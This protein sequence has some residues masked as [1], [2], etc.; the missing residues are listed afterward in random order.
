MAMTQN[1]QKLIS[2]ENLV[3]GKI[4]CDTII[5]NHPNPILL[6]FVEE[7]NETLYFKDYKDSNKIAGH[8]Y[9]LL[10]GK[11]CFNAAISKYWM[12]Y[13]GKHNYNL[14]TSN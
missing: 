3:P 9:L 12:E 7:K 1:T 10:K 2:S 4:Y 8:F 11:I 14:L 5:P 6:E 13:T